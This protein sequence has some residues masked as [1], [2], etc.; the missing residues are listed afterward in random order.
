MSY[1]KS[2]STSR[3]SMMKKA[4]F[5]AGVGATA[6]TAGCTALVG[7]DNGGSENGQDAAPAADTD[8]EDL[9]EVEMDWAH[10]GPPD[11]TLRSHR[12]ATTIKEYMET[13]SDGRFTVN[14]RPGGEV[15]STRET[16][17]QIQD[18]VI[19]GG[20]LT[21]AH[22]APFFSGFN[23]YT[24][25]YLFDDVDLALAVM[26]GPFG[27][28]LKEA[29]REDTGQRIISV[30][31]VGGFQTVSSNIGP[32]DNVDVLDGQDIRTMS[33]D[34]H[35]EFYSQLGMNP[36]PMDIGELYEA[37]DTGVMDAQ[38]NP[39]EVMMLFSLYEVQ[40]YKLLNGPIM[41]LLWPNV[42]DE[43]YQ[44]LHPTYQQWLDQAGRE[45]SIAGRRRT[46]WYRNNGHPFIRDQGM[47]LT[48]PDE[49]FIEE[50]R[51][52]TL[53]PVEDTIRDVMD[54]PELLDDLFEAVEETRESLGYDALD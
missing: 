16:M 25:P 50:I 32:I 22:M 26:D 27:D 19:Q 18:N 31:D 30:V 4:G 28:Q 51:D 29:F 36:E 5:A 47:T 15:G 3:R 44:G 2:G 53:E 48:E 24:V 42:N 9:P 34:T 23:V 13:K 40:E 8:V 54:R 38:A 14:I 39:V 17:E 12:V 6:L 37:L 46:R 52:R 49:E 7:D 1:Q 10:V 11:A 45:A 35:L 20:Q 41:S 43:W 21:G 33:M